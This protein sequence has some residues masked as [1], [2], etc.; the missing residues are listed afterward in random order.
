MD[1]A[2]GPLLKE[3]KHI[4]TC[5]CFLIRILCTEPLS[6]IILNAIGGNLLEDIQNSCFNQ[7]ILRDLNKTPPNFLLH[8]PDVGVIGFALLN[9]ELFQSS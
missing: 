2:H 6:D 9:P 3:S 8:G 5:Y 1:D 7:G 4:L